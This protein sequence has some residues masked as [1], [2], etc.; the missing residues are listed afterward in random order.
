[1]RVPTLFLCCVTAVVPL[2]C[3]AG[4]YVAFSLHAAQ[5]RLVREDGGADVAQM[6][7]ITRLAGMVVDKAGQDVILVG[8][9][10]TALP[11]LQLDDLVVSMRSLMMQHEWPLVSLDN[12][13][14]TKSTRRQKVR[15]AGHIAGTQLGKSLLDADVIL[16][17]LALG[18]RSAAIWGVKSYA[19]LCEEA[20]RR[21]DKSSASVLFWFFPMDVRLVEREG[22]FAVGG[23]AVGTKTE[24]LRPGGSAPT[25][26]PVGDP[27]GAKFAHDMT[28][29]FEDLAGQFPELR[30]VEQLYSAVAIAHG[31]RGTKDLPDLGYFL[32]D[33][34]IRSVQTPE[35][36]PVLTAAGEQM[37]L[38][39]GVE[40]RAL[41]L[42]LQDGDVTA[43]REAVLRSRPSRDSLAWRLPLIGWQMPG[44]K[45]PLPAT[46]DQGPNPPEQVGQL[47]VSINRQAAGA[48]VDSWRPVPLSG[49]TSLKDSPAFYVA[50]NF[51][52]QFNS[53]QVGGVMLSG[54]AAVAEQNGQ[55]AK[56]HT[57]FSLVAEGDNAALSEDA[58]RRFVTAL[59]AVYFSKTD[60]GISIDPI[61]PG[62]KQH[63]VRYIGNVMNSDLGRVMREADYTMKQW[64]VGSAR[65]DIAGFMNPDDIA[66]RSGVAYVG[67]GSRFWFVPEDLTFRRADNL[68]LFDHGRMTVRTEFLFNN[69]QGMHSDP[70]NEQWA[71]WFTAHYNEVAAKYPV[72]A[73][74]F[75]YAKLVALARNLKESGVPLLWF[76]LAN[77]DLALTEDSPG[78]VEALVKDSEHFDGLR[79]EGGVQL[80]SPPHYILDEKALAAINEAH[81]VAGWTNRS[82]TSSTLAP[83]RDEPPRQ[84][85]SF[86]LGENNYSL[87]PQHSLTCGK[88]RREHRYQTDF[89]LRED[90]QPGLELVRW[91]DESLQE[92]GDFGRGWRLV[93]PYRVEPDGNER[94]NFLNVRAPSR[95]KLHNIISGK[96]EVLTFSTNRYS[97][98]GWVPARLEQSEVIGLFPL[99]DATFRLE[100]KLGNSFLF[101]EAGYLTQMNLGH[102]YRL[103]IEYTEDASTLFAPNFLRIR[104]GAE[105]TQ[106]ANALVPRAITL[107]DEASGDRETYLFTM[108]HREVGYEPADDAKRVNRFIALLSD[109]SFRLEAQEHN[110]FDFDGSGKL[111]T[112]HLS[113]SSRLIKAITVAGQRV[114]FS[115]SLSPSGHP[116]ICRASLLG[117]GAKGVV[118]YFQDSNGK[119]YSVQSGQVE[120]TAA[121]CMTA[122]R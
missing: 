77:K 41:L 114:E 58:Y 46:I 83:E 120:D 62:V 35:Q 82:A 88:D 9:R 38:M 97:V 55:S 104:A 25:Q 116:Y 11:P 52:R 15:F 68:L 23:L 22:V 50:P 69:R 19:A 43:L 49:L 84:P 6:S 105:T 12:T 110:Q 108:K 99:S 3:T 95:M 51:P 80:V 112:L 32:K 71:E 113:H 39:G 73:E 94:I 106:F 117:S 42:R 64:A 79:I 59:W 31:L 107:V 70:A 16:K 27:M 48:G 13:P 37:D 92:D 57:L 1:M 121:K 111:Q 89:A 65:P 72:Y 30:R 66:G 91:F 17:E 56:A 78:T 63:L 47:G 101:N 103:G 60:P 53:P 8:T 54:T 34:K 100:D 81:T 44:L 33:Y 45:T 118:R 86:H 75:D 2:A 28:S 90:G 24:L 67:A 18:K 10:E 36:M 7:G 98:A 40:L 20:A 4:D 76:L 21:G 14:E 122:N 87:V 93:I 119:L 109:G 115:Y 85:A 96:D 29:A 74:L 26:P 5:A 61:A 102:T